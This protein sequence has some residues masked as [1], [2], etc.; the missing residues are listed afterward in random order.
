M[1]SWLYKQPHLHF[2]VWH[3]GWKEAPHFIAAYI[4]ETI[5]PLKT[6][7]M[8]AQKYR[9]PRFSFSVVLKKKAHICWRSQ[10]PVCYNVVTH[11]IHRLSSCH[12]TSATPREQL[13]APDAIKSPLSVLPNR[14]VEIQA[15][16]SNTP[17]CQSHY[18]DQNNTLIISTDWQHTSNCLNVVPHERL[19]QRAAVTDGCH[20][21]TFVL[22]Y[23]CLRVLKSFKCVSLSFIAA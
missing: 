9:K 21:D 7:R 16:P 14:T 15:L 8:W 18:N 20:I 1:S 13:K 6:L 5:S 11:R 17:V 12:W 22:K 10:L 2:K 19:N 3:H 4:N 23:C